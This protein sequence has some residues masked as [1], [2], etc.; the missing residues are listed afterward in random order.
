[1]AVVQESLRLRELSGGRYFIV[2]HT[3]LA[4]HVLAC[5]GQHE[6]GLAMLGDGI[7]TAGQMPTAYLEACGRMHRAE[8][9]L[10]LGRREQASEDIS[11][12]LG[13]MR[14]NA[15]CHLW[16]WTPEARETVLR[17]AVTERIEVEYARKL[18]MQ[19]LN[20]AL[21]DDGRSVPLLEFKTLGGLCIVLRSRSLL[22][23][24]DLTPTQRELLGMLLASPGLKIPIDTVQLHLWP[25]SA[26]ET[27]R[28]K[29]DTLISR[30]RKALA[31]ALPES[32][33][34]G[35]L[36]RGKGM[37]WLEHCRVDA[38][39]FMEKTS[40]G[41]KH[42]QLQEF[43]QADNAFAEA[44]AMWT[45]EFLPEVVGNDRLRAFREALTSTFSSLAWAWSDLLHAAGR[46]ATALRVVEKALYTDPLNEKLYRRLFLVKGQSSAV[47]AR[48]VLN[49]FAAQ[50]R[51]DGYLE[52][53]IEDVLARILATSSGR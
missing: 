8:I 35:Y 38:V 49:R 45:G 3:I 24:E 40:Q 51:Q 53:E 19:T 10:G 11:H 22:R 28:I 50:L 30:L 17:F 36:C 25:D 34:Q 16:G 31:E 37:L 6:P 39:Q 15:Y 13:L 21:P 7:A 27:I 5:R 46:G 20:A 48:Q 29:C 33:V 9:L 47:S 2:L 26:P 12:A 32:A 23:A 18:A 42:L 4:G 14:R 43:W 1:V 41:M 44:E 52:R